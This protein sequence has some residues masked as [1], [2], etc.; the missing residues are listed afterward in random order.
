MAWSLSK[1]FQKLQ[2]RLKT[3]GFKGTADVHEKYGR[4]L[5]SDGESND[6]RTTRNQASLHKTSIKARLIFKDRKP[7]TIQ[8]SP[9]NPKE[10]AQNTL[11]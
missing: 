8:D 11:P 4:I 7:M 9:H 5:E 2:G 1:S 6:H 10:K 3:I